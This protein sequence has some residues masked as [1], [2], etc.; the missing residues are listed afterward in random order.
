MMGTLN[1]LSP[2]HLP[3][4]QVASYPMAPG[5]VKCCVGRQRVGVGGGGRVAGR[6][7]LVAEDIRGEM[8]LLAQGGWGQRGGVC[9]ILT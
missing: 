5:A 8:V 1:P 6:E 4:I 3:L 9:C 7:C 2:H